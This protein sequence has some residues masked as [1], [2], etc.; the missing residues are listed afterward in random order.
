MENYQQYYN[1]AAI[2]TSVH[3]K[4]SGQNSPC[5]D[6][7]EKYVSPVFN[8]SLYNQQ[9]YSNTNNYFGDCESKIMDFSI[10]SRHSKSVSYKNQP[11]LQKHSFNYTSS[12]KRKYSQINNVDL[13]QKLNINNLPFVRSNS[14]SSN[15]ENENMSQQNVN[16]QSNFNNV[17]LST[18]NQTPKSKKE[19]LKKWLSRI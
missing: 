7:S 10:L 12:L 9:N 6:E 14:F 19:E 15:L 17:L 11:P 3:A 4:T 13:S 18:M 8:T 2:Y 16:N 1:I 5:P